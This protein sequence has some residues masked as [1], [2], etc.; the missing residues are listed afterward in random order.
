MRRFKSALLLLSLFWI[1]T[2]ASQAADR[3]DDA[4]WLGVLDVKGKASLVIVTSPYA[5]QARAFFQTFDSRA[6]QQTG[7][8]VVI[9][10]DQGMSSQMSFLSPALKPAVRETPGI[11]N[12]AFQNGIPAFPAFLVID[13]Q[14]K[15]FSVRF[16][17]VNIQDLMKDM[18]EVVQ[19]GR[20]QKI[21]L[22]MDETNLRFEYQELGV[23]GDS[24]VEG[25]KEEF[26]GL[27]VL[28]IPKFMESLYVD[29]MGRSLKSTQILA[30]GTP[31]RV[32]AMGTVTL[33][34]A[35]V[36]RNIVADA[37]YVF[38]AGSETS[39]GKTSLPALSGTLLIDGQ[40]MRPREPYS[41]AHEYTQ[42]VEGQ[43]REVEFKIADSDY[44]DNGGHLVLHIHRLLDYR[45]SVAT[46]F[47]NQSIV[48]EV[49]NLMRDQQVEEALQM[50][51]KTLK[52][53]GDDPLLLNL[54]GIIHLKL[55]ESEMTENVVISQTSHLG[56]AM[57]NLRSALEKDGKSAVI[58]N[59]WG[60]A[61]RKVGDLGRAREAFRK[62]LQLQPDYEPARH[63]LRLLDEEEAMA[64]PSGPRPSS[65]LSRV[66]ENNGK[67]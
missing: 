55:S 5:P 63:N 21:I 1:L 38:E 16:G 40:G 52:D 32:E 13:T 62:S 67:K 28:R 65:T 11:Q 2:V 31:Y 3:G 56:Q 64:L 50:I 10:V 42:D 29:A 8:Q 44:L 23:T 4:S 25:Q 18:D 59:S 37:A 22:E 6:F 45:L 15:I 12:A 34:P 66:Q 43:G 33:G 9:I 47:Q 27:V 48:D 49:L 57:F 30:V 17:R 35:I 53:T 58:E 7:R 36:G 26:R 20:P 41:V 46:R 14:G 24:S 19:S 60:V 51:Q 39:W 54:L 61:Q